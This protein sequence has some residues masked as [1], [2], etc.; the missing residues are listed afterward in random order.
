MVRGS[1]GPPAESSRGVAAS[2][3]ARPV[4]CLHQ[5]NAD[6]IQTEALF[7]GQPKPQ[8]S[9]RGI[10]TQAAS[11]STRVPGPP[12]GRFLRQATRPC[13]GADPV[14]PRTQD[15]QR[16]RRFSVGLDRDASSVAPPTCRIVGNPSVALCTASPVGR[17]LAFFRCRELRMVQ[18]LP[19]LRGRHAVRYAASPMSS[20]RWG[21]EGR[22]VR[23]FVWS[24]GGGHAHRRPEQHVVLL[25]PSD[26]GGN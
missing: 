12:P 9:V 11:R 10:S 20:L 1:G 24:P 26:V 2:H 4:P 17:Q 22:N 7:Y 23:G 15:A 19:I 14:T 3:A 6:P 8:D 18:T 25:L 5:D 13:G 16:G 21:P